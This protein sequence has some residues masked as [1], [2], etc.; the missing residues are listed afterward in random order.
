MVHSHHSP[1]IVALYSFGVN[2]EK[3]ISQN[4]FMTARDVARLFEVSPN[5]IAR[6]AR[7]GKVPSVVTPGGRR[8]FP[9]EGIQQYVDAMHVHQTTRR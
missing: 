9:R 8:K 7:R 2:G 6:W 4:R 5:T 3:E 1:Q